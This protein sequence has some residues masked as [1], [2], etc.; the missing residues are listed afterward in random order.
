MLRR[1]RRGFTLI[2]VLIV[3]TIIGVLATLIIPRLLGSV[4]TANLAEVYTRLGALTRAQERYMDLNLAPPLAVTCANPPANCG[5]TALQ[6]LGIAD[7]P[8]D[9][10]RYRC[11]TTGPTY[12]YCDAYRWMSGAITTARI[13]KF[14]IHDAVPAQVGVW[15][16]GA[17]GSPGYVRADTGT[18]GYNTKP[19]VGC[20]ANF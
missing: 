1:Y 15:Y 8:Q 5:S 16:C 12:A 19:G 7:F 13:I 14:Y 3:V 4:E 20:K 10:F 9:K 17:A 6:S 11:V 18:V 2:E